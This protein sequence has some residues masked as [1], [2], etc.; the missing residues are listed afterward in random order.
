MN[1]IGNND[2]VDISLKALHK[3]SHDLH[4][5]I[6]PAYYTRTRTCDATE[7]VP[8]YNPFELQYVR[9]TDITE[10]SR[11]TVPFFTNRWE[12]LGAVEPGDWDRRPNFK[13]DPGYDRK[14]WFNTV[15][16]SPAYDDSLFHQSL[17]DHFRHGVDWFETA[18]IETVL[19]H[20]DM[21]E[22]VWHG[23]ESRA[24][25]R[26]RCEYID[27]LYEE[28][29]EKGYVEQRCLGNDFKSSR[30]Q[31]IM[32]DV[33]RTGELLFVDGRHRLSI[34]KILDLDAVPVVFGV[35]HQAFFE[36]DDRVLALIDS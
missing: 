36:D 12:L 2:I 25:V 8:T 19:K 24:D 9:P 26:D 27:D 11:R 33:G 23:C 1:L 29:N 30:E 13:F 16:P 14:T 32:V 28:M 15:F 4:W 7:Y 3:A 21:G 5:R 34:A 22:P 31:E 20:I 10:L 17:V 35:F 18:Y 6:A